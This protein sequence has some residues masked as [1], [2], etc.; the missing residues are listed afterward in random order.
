[1]DILHIGAEGYG[2]KPRKLFAKQAAFQAGVDGLYN[3]LIAEKI[4]INGHHSIS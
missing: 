2:I 1:M 4:L 3:R